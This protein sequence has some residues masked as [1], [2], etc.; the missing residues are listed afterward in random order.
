MITG[1][2]PKFKT[3]RV[4]SKKKADLIVKSLREQNRHTF[5]DVFYGFH[6]KRDY[7]VYYWT[8]RGVI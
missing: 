1:Y 6:N 2:E 3:V 4:N 8:K 7:L 5:Y